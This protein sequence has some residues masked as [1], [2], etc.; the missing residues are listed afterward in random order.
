LGK[1]AKSNLNFGGTHKEL[2]CPGGEKAFIDLM[3]RESIQFQRQ[4]RWF[5]TLVSKEAN[6]K[7]IQ[8]SIA[9]TQASDQ[10][11]MDMTQGQK[12]S[13]IVAWT[14]FK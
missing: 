11:V 6:L 5:T 7:G 12:K 4:C 2:W 14:Y 3:I 10:R 9:Q 1:A 8:K 13:R